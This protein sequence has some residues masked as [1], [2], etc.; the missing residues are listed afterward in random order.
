MAITGG[1]FNEMWAQH[2]GGTHGYSVTVQG[3]G[4]GAIC[5]ATLIS[6]WGVDDNS[7]S[8][9]FITQAVS[10]SGVEEFPKENRTNSDLVTKIYRNRLTS[11]TFKC[12]VFRGKSMG[13]WSV[14]DWE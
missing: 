14:Y 9:I 11:V 8:D 1:R 13:H 6:H 4:V 5:E 7:A 12:S 2:F 10:A 3:K